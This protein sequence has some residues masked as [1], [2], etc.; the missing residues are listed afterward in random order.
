MNVFI[1]S[2]FV[3]GL[4]FQQEHYE[5]CNR[6]L[7][8]VVAGSYSLHVPQYALTEVFHTLHHRR[9]ERLKN[10]EYFRQEIAQHRREAEAEATETDLLVQLLT[11][12][13]DTRTQ[14]QTD[15]LFAITTQ[16]AALA[17]GPALTEHVLREAQALR[18][19]HS[20]A[21][22]DA[23]VYSSVLAGL[24]QLPSAT[25]KLFITRNDSDFKKPAIVQELQGFNCR[26]LANF[27]GAADL[28]A[29][30]HS[31]SL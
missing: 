31:P 24:R 25:P 7:A 2:N 3:L 22:Q 11:S 1:E 29:S 15:R 12:L 28:L 13:L 27:S 18:E 16:L 14:V 17:P 30:G 21:S 9:N 10:R 20:F 19:L 5:A 4:A 23:L 6:I 8:G 26:L